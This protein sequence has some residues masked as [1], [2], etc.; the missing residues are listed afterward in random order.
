MGAR[1]LQTRPDKGRSKAQRRRHWLV[2]GMKRPRLEPKC[3]GPK[4]AVPAGAVRCEGC[5]ATFKTKMGLS[6]HELHVHPDIRNRKRIQARKRGSSSYQR[7]DGETGAQMA[8]V[9]NRDSSAEDC[10]AKRLRSH[11]RKD[12]EIL[13]TSIPPN[14]PNLPEDGLLMLL[15]EVARK[16]LSEGEG[17]DADYLHVLQV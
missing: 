15:R 16:M 12:S 8:S 11:V 17:D 5:K 7:T 1:A 10:P 9:V 13:C 2:R 6:I 3:R 4:V 14:Q